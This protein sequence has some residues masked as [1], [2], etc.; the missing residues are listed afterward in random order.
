MFAGK[1]MTIGRREF[2]V[3]ALT[4]GQLRTAALEMITEH[5]KMLD[6]GQTFQSYELRG[7]IILMALQRNYPDL[8]E[9]T[10]FEL[11]DVENVLPVWRVVLG[12]SG[13]DQGE[14]PAATTGA[15]PAPGATG[16]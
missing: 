16:A 2:V 9:E 11:L 13:F 14:V 3:P 12:N 1:T 8:T 15:N 10:L 6:G 5:D 7:K 4:L